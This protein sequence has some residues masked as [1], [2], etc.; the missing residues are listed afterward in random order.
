MIREEFVFIDKYFQRYVIV[1]RRRQEGS[2]R[3]RRS[4]CERVRGRMRVKVSV[5][6]EAPAT[7]KHTPIYCLYVWMYQITF[8]VNNAHYLDVRQ[9]MKRI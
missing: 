3:K 8:A 7:H 5:R 1:N 4:D 2:K 6:V 9:E